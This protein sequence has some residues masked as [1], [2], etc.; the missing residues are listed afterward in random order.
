MQPILGQMAF[1]NKLKWWESFDDNA[2]YYG[3]FLIAG[4]NLWSSQNS[5]P[6]LN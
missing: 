3:P 5:L 2:K 4:A 1:R 6:D